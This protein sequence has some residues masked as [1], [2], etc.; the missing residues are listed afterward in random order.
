MTTL[1]QRVI[2]SQTAAAGFAPRKPSSFATDCQRGPGCEWH[3]LEVLADLLSERGDHRIDPGDFMHMGVSQSVTGA[4]VYLFKHCDTR[5][6]LNL[7]S[8]GHAYEY[9]AS[10]PTGYY[11]LESLPAAIAHALS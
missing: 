10:H 5:R 4:H 6:Y 3:P 11:E 9:K 8:N 7:D 2:K 1:T